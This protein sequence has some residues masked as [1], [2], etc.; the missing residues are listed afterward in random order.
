MTDLLFLNAKAVILD[1]FYLHTLEESVKI[2]NHWSDEI[3]FS[4]FK[5]N[6]CNY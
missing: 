5:T 2:I 1:L 4:V 6:L 3:R